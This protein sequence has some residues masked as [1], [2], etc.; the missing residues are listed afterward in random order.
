MHFNQD[1]CKPEIKI[2]DFGITKI[3]DRTFTFTVD[4]NKCTVG[5]SAPELYCEDNTKARFSHKIDVWALGCI[6]S[7]M[8]TGIIPWR[9]KAKNM[10]KI[11]SY[12]VLKEKFPIPENCDENIRKLIEFCTTVNP[13]KRVNAGAVSYLTNKILKKE[14]IIDIKLEDSYYV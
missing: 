9:N 3:T 6:I 5:Y 8:F 11:Q 13:D 4:N 7:Y 1:S 2:L 14:S 10:I 12:L